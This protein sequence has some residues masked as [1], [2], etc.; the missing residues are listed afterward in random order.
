MKINET[1]TMNVKQN[2][3]NH[4]NSIGYTMKIM[5]LIKKQ[6]H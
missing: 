6:K 5:D 4:K 3:F 2:N 1:A